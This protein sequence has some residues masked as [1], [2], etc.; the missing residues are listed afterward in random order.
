[1]IQ[2]VL[3]A[4]EM[5]S[6]STIYSSEMPSHMHLLLVQDVFPLL[7]HIC[8]WL[9][10]YKLAACLRNGRAVERGQVGLAVHVLVVV[11]RES[12]SASDDHLE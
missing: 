12:L 7:P 3:S 2:V 9:V 1:M 6:P 5:L 8:V 4:T 10:Q 11:F